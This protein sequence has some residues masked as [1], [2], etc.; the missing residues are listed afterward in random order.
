MKVAQSPSLWFGTEEAYYAF[1][2]ACT[3]LAELQMAGESALKA[4]VLS[5]GGGRSNSDPF[6]L[7]PLWTVQDGVATVEINGSLINGTA[8]FMRLFGVVGYEDIK[9][10]LAE[11]LAAKDV[12]SIMLAID[13]G[14]GAVNGL[15]DAGSFIQQADKIKPVVAFTDGN[16]LSAAYWLGASARQIVGTRTSQIGS[17][18]T[19]IVHTEYSKMLEAD[20]IKKTVIKYGE[21]KALGNPFEPLT[22]KAK[23]QIQTLADTAGKIFVEYAADRR[24][25]TPEKFQ[26]TMGEGRVM[27]GVQAKEVGLID[28]VMS[29]ADLT[30]FAKTLDKQKTS[31]HNPRTN[32]EDSAMKITLSKKTV[33]AIAAG[34]ALD[35]LGLSAL[36]ANAE[37]V[38]LDAAGIAALTA[39]ATEVIAARDVASKVAVTAAADAAKVEMKAEL[40]KSQLNLKVATDEVTLLKAASTQLTEQ[41][42][43]SSEFGGKSSSVVKASINVMSVALGGKAGLAD[44]LTGDALVAEHDRIAGEFK[45]KFPQGGV[46]AVNTAFK[47]GDTS[48]TVPPPAFLAAMAGKGQK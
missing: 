16:M 45:K 30:N 27:M 25:T 7:Q 35:A 1:E 32:A 29:Y 10:A 43:V 20:G 26:K 2:A 11:A 12:K 22:E 13:S 6:A 41:L 5:A 9:G 38:Q 15:E 48:A 8:G 44:A 23:E 24:G 21:Y 17:V 28:S 39:E 4:A 42:R 46:A 33:L 18:G 37:G 3:R 19:L 36:D 40:D 14:G 34:A 31:N 47:P